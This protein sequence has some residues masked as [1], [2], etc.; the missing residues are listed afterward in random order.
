[1]ANAF[2]GRGA[3]LMNGPF[4]EGI[5]QMRILVIFLLAISFGLI[6]ELTIHPAHACSCG[7]AESAK[8][9][10]D[11]SDVIFEGSVIKVKR[12]GF[13]WWGRQHPDNVKT[14]FKIQRPVKGIDG[15]NIWVSHGTSGA[16]CGVNFEKGKT[17]LVFAGRAEDGK[18][19]T[20]LCSAYIFFPVED[21]E[22]E[23]A[24][25]NQNTN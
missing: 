10:I 24:K 14:K 21:Y 13:L 9:H 8:A 2:E 17:H 25:L 16:S 3:W 7:R 23:F 1:M 19:S 18:V 11:G 15:D 22:A 20:H 12:P 6:T 4:Q 5:N